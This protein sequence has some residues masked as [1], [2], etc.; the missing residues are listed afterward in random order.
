MSS[1][2]APLSLQAELVRAQRLAE[3]G[4]L[5]S[6]RA[7]LH[8]HVQAGHAPPIVHAVLAQIDIRT[9]DYASA[10]AHLEHVLRQSPHE[11][12]VLELLADVHRR[13]GSFA[14]AIP[15]LERVMQRNP[16]RFEAWSLLGTVLL[17][18]QKF[19]EALEVSQ[20][21]LAL[22]PRRPAGRRLAALVAL[23]DNRFEDAD[24]L[25][26][27]WIH[28]HP[29][30]AEAQSMLGDLLS[31]AR[32][33][34]DAEQLF[35]SAR[36]RHPKD[37][38]LATRYADHLGRRGAFTE[39]RA[40]FAE[41]LAADATLAV[42]HANVGIAEYW[43][44]NHDAAIRHLKRATSMEPANASHW[45]NLSHAHL[46]NGDLERGFEVYEHRVGLQGAPDWWPQRWQGEP[47]VPGTPLYLDSEQGLGDG[48]QFVRFA[49]D[50]AERGAHVVVRA[51]PRLIPLLSTVRGVAEV[52]STEDAPPSHARRAKLLSLPRVVGVRSRDDLGH[53]VPYLSVEPDRVD[54]WRARLH[55]QGFRIG[56]TWQG[57]PR[58]THDF[59]RSPP[60]KYYLPLTRVP[61]VTV[62]SLQKFHGVEQLEAVDQT[63]HP[64]IPLGPELDLDVAFLDTAATMCALDLVITSDTSTAHLAG[65]LGVPTWVVIP[66]APD[67]RWPRDSEQTPWYPSMRLFRQQTPG[68]WPGVFTRVEAA[69]RHAT[70]PAHAPSP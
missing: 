18:L 10:Q 35:L 48:I 31:R 14:R 44:G 36:A 23:E 25:L 6:A 46:Q 29:Q 58:Y 54:R 1:N 20:R 38:T 41:V 43:L 9:A 2:R 21:L 33:F 55:P 64:I 63:R 5:E 67:W 53:R 3:S 27:T 40:V 12:A 30:N 7:L 57:N 49:N 22:A 4:Q 61:G 34:D 52:R 24:R 59:L 65:A 37:R 45:W 68:D 16:E 47:L 42:N 32:R 26:R 17:N 28:E 13:T 39:A 8:R 60:L 51:H 66:Y 56:V 19:P 50:A 11:P 62:Y 70:R 69:L 15:L